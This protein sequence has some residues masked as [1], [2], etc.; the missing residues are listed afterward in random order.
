MGLKPNAPSWLRTGQRVKQAEVLPVDV[1]LLPQ[2]WKGLQHGVLRRNGGTNLDLTR[3]YTRLLAGVDLLWVAV[4]VG[5]VWTSHPPYIGVAI[6]SVS[7]LPPTRRKD[8]APTRSL[9]VHL[10][11]ASSG[12]IARWIDNAVERI[13]EYGR[14]Q[15]CKQIFLLSRR[16]WRPYVLRF[17]GKFDATAYGRDRETSVGSKGARYR[18]GH[19][20]RVL[21]A[22]P[23]MRKCARYEPT[24]VTYFVPQQKEENHAG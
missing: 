9:T 13:S 3:T 19:W 8:F 4:P 23:G 18:P 10:A 24:R 20:R 7:E 12:M 6:T 16:G 2:V 11:A 21:I 22:P 14:E 15:G 5:D 17:F 1:S